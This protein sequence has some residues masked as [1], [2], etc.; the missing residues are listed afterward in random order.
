MSYQHV[1]VMFLAHKH[2]LKWV[3]ESFFYMSYKQSFHFPHSLPASVPSAMQ[4]G[5]TTTSTSR[6]E[7][8]STKK[9]PETG[10]TATK[11]WIK[12]P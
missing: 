11:K 6:T 1:L 10:K 12:L 5:S 3:Y 7:A 4:G 9:S 2:P 8:V